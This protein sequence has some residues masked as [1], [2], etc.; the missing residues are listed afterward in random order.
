MSFSPAALACTAALALAA[1]VAATAQTTPGIG[2]MAD[3]QLARMDYIENCSGC[4]GVQGRSAPAPL[5]EL[6]DRVGYFL[7]TPEARAYLIRLPN[8][9]HSRIAD[10]ERLADLLNF[11]TFV[12]GGSSV[13]KGTQPFS[14]AEVARERPHVLASASLKQERARHVEQ[15]I[16]RCGA[17]ASLR[18]LYPG[19]KPRG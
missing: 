8:V 6:R 9:A 19:E 17:P 11:M 16:R 14:A 12:I 2:L 7:C 15:A 3:P 10:N 1:C 18:R 13:P 5:P 4:H